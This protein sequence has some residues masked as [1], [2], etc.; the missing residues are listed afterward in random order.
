MKPQDFLQVLQKVQLDSSHKQA[1]MEVLGPPLPHA[2]PACASGLCLEVTSA[3]SPFS[4]QGCHLAQA[5]GWGCWGR[6]TL[7]SRALPSF[8]PAEP[9]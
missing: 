5:G 2:P 8:G 7:L 4:A 6:R 9:G 1:I 3:T